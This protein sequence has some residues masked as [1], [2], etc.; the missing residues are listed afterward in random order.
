[1]PTGLETSVYGVVHAQLCRWCTLYH[2][3]TS[4]RIGR[5]SGSLLLACPSARAHTCTLS[6]THLLNH[7]Q[8]TEPPPT[9][10]MNGVNCC[11][12]T[13]STAST[14]SVRQPQRLAPAER[15]NAAVWASVRMHHVSSTS[16]NEPPST[17]QERQGPQGSSTKRDKGLASFSLASSS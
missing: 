5:S 15:V 10:S 7:P 17:G 4:R 8:P 1:M 13:V 11:P 16:A 9:A 3:Y 12:G 6:L 2:Q 14:D